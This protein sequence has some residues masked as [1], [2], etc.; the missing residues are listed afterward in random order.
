MH[1]GDLEVDLLVGERIVVEVDGYYHALKAKV[2]KDAAKGRHL[3]DLG[4]VVLRI[5]GAEAKNPGRLREFGDKVQS[6]YDQESA[7]HSQRQTALTKRV[8][9]AELSIFKVKLEQEEQ[10]KAKVKAKKKAEKKQVGGSKKLTDEEL[11]L[12]A[13]AEMPKPRRK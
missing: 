8:P 2:S 10:E 3:E 9:Q 5:T 1:V 7:V 13:I 11:F 4:Y 12:Q 6:H